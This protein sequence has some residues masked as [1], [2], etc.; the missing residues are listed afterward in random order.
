M[1]RIATWDNAKYSWNLEKRFVVQIRTS[2]TQIGVEMGFFSIFILAVLK[3]GK[4]FHIS[5]LRRIS[6]TYNP[7]ATFFRDHTFMTSKKNVL[8]LHTP[9]P[10]YSLSEWVLIGR[11]PPPLDVET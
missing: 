1:L 10:L 3:E 4:M 8:F 7:T 11:D 9:S 5:W 2:Q 6:L